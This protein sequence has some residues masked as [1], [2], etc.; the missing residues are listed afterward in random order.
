MRE[1]KYK[2]W[3]IVWNEKIIENTISNVIYARQWISSHRPK[4]WADI[5]VFWD[6]TRLSIVKF[7]GMAGGWNGTGGHTHFSGMIIT[8]TGDG[9]LIAWLILH[10]KQ[11]KFKK[12]SKYDDQQSIVTLTW[13]WFFR[14][15]ARKNNVLTRRRYLSATPIA[16]SK[17]QL[18][19]SVSFAYR[20]LL[21]ESMRAW[22][23]PSKIN[24]I[25]SFSSSG[26]LRLK[27]A[28]IFTMSADK[29]GLKYWMRA[30]LRISVYKLLTCGAIYMSNSKLSLISSSNFKHDAYFDS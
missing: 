14:T 25:T 22:I 8:R 29:Y 19:W 20:T 27:A 1:M 6:P 2:L 10:K 5:W 26:T 4:I 17:V 12:K 30:R 7:A 11:Y 3:F 24:C 13:I 28:A 15:A 9:V 23:W 16:F 21:C 18:R